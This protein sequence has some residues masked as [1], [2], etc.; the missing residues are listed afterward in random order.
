M[1]S[2]ICQKHGN[3]TGT[4]FVYKRGQLVFEFFQRTMIRITLTLSFLFQS[5]N[6]TKDSIFRATKICLWAI[7]FLHH[8]DQLLNAGK[9]R[10]FRKNISS[11]QAQSGN[12]VSFEEPSNFLLQNYLSKLG[13]VVSSCLPNSQCIKLHSSQCSEHWSQAEVAATF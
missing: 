7:T 3:N 2:G 6:G 10:K 5:F 9:W 8:I 12:T 4:F 11:F 13:V 1:I